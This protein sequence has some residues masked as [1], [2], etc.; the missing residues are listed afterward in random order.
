MLLTDG[1]AM[2][3]YS[4]TIQMIPGS[5]G[6]VP[7]HQEQNTG[8]NNLSLAPRNY[9]YMRTG[10]TDGIHDTTYNRNRR[11]ASSGMSHMGAFIDTYA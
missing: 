6:F 3:P 11:L 2:V 10:V 5:S 7:A 9:P 8:D 1:Y 4:G